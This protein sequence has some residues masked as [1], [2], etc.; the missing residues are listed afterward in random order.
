MI[1]KKSQHLLPQIYSGR[2]AD[3]D[4][5]ES[6]AASNGKISELPSTTAE[7]GGLVFKAVEESEIQQSREAY[8]R[9]QDAWETGSVSTAANGEN[10]PLYRNDAAS[11]YFEAKKR[12]YLANG[13]RPMTPSSYDMMGMSVSVHEMARNRKQGWRASGC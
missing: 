3:F 13:P 10:T 11:D 6:Y 9:E 4:Y 5:S 7:T 8:L 1:H 2:M 12:E